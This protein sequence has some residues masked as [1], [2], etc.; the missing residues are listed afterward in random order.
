MV[1]SGSN[2]APVIALISLDLVTCIEINTEKAVKIVGLLIS[3][4]YLEIEAEE[5]E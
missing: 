1:A 4:A 5:F 3:R 2:E